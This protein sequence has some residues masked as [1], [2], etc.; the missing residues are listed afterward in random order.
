[1][2][3]AETIYLT[4]FIAVLTAGFVGYLVGTWPSK[5]RPMYLG[6]QE[7][8][9][10]SE[11][12][13]WHENEM[14]AQQR[15]NAHAAMRAQ[16]HQYNPE[17]PGLPANADPETERRGREQ[18][19]PAAEETSLFEPTVEQVSRARQAIRDGANGTPELPDYL[20][21]PYG[22]RVPWTE[23]LELAEL[24][25]KRTPPPPWPKNDA[26]A[27]A[28]LATLAKMRAEDKE[29]NRLIRVAIGPSFPHVPCATPFLDKHAPKFAARARKAKPKKKGKK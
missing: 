25:A 29:I 6:L 7:V 23:E 5:R 28:A 27:K 4:S 20:R 24:I 2:T 19:G 15:A 22:R 26:E 14:A 13:A 18:S 21:E 8:I 9:P 3:D 1:M 16:G 11:A 10:V 17:S 12:R